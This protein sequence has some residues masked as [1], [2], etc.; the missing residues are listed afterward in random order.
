MRTAI[1]QAISPETRTMFSETLLDNLIA[2]ILAT[3]VPK[4]TQEDEL[5]VVR[6][7]NA[8][9]SVLLDAYDADYA[10][11][12]DAGADY[13][14]IREAVR[15]LNNEEISFGRLV[16]IVR[17][18]VVAGIRAAVPVMACGHA[19][20]FFQSYQANPDGPL[21]FCT[22]CH[23]ELTRTRKEDGTPQYVTTQS[24]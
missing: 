10:K 7:I 11:A 13:V 14:T 3:P 16:E 23:V 22:D 21:G 20:T 1:I 19:S 8:A 17:A 5:T 4:D 15:D 2:D 18:A 6:A 12:R 24:E 9:Q